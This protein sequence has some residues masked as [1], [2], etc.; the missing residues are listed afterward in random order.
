M[1]EATVCWGARFYN[2]VPS[3][4]HTLSFPQSFDDLVP[5]W[6]QLVGETLHPSLDFPLLA[7][8]PVM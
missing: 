6:P 4:P 5:M 8:P 1:W 2:Q 7:I 3:A